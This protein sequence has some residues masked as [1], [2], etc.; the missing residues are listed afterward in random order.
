MRFAVDK[1]KKTVMAGYAATICTI[2]LPF[3]IGYHMLFFAFGTLGASNT[4]DYIA[5]FASLEFLLIRAFAFALELGCYLAIVIAINI[6]WN[7]S[8]L[9]IAQ[10]AICAGLLTMLTHTVIDIITICRLLK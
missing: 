8:R 5:V 1:V 6:A 4:N 9:S 2:A 7:R 10:Q 3:I